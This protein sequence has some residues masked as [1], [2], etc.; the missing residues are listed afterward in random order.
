MIVCFECLM[1]IFVVVVVFGICTC[2]TQLSRFHLERRSRNTL[3]IITII[4]IIYCC[5][6]F[7]YLHLFNATEQVSLG[8]AL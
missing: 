7:W 2:S 5:C 3:I 6:C 4:I 8:K 1:C